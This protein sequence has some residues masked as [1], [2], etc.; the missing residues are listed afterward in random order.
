MPRDELGV[1]GP[2]WAHG[3]E[4]FRFA[5]TAISLV[6]QIPAIAIAAHSGRPVAVLEALLA[7]A[8]CCLLPLGR[9]HPGPT[10]VAIAV[11]TAPA[12]IMAGPPVAAVPVAF[13]VVGAIVRAKRAWTWSTLAGLAVLGTGATVSFTAVPWAAARLL[14]VTLALCLIAALTEGARSRRER[15]RAAAREVAVRR[16]SAAEAERLRIARELHDILAHSLSEI[17]VQAGMGLHLFDTQ[18]QQARDALTAIRAT[19]GT[20]LDEVRG[21]LGVLR[22]GTEP[23]DLTPEP[24]LQRVDELVAAGARR[25]I[26]VTVEN[27]IP[28]EGATVPP[29]P[30]QTALFRI[31]QEALTNVATHAGAQSAHVVLDVDDAT[32]RAEIVNPPGTAR[33]PT[34]DHVGRGLIGMR[35]R[36][37]LLRGTAHAGPTPDGGWAVTARIPRAARSDEARS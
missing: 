4:P 26:A 20:A 25:G 19:S 18:P 14:I 3:R 31:V 21:V 27:H 23:A 9:R 13:A 30:V 24:T 12:I 15:Y 37:E 1:H 22:Q 8:A 34:T 17:S 7:V 10:L 28:S 29:A 16:Q 2:P 33:N 11:L 5:P 35:E 36:A 6:L 32:Y